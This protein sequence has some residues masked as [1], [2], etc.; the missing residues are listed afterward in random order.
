MGCNAFERL[1]SHNQLGFAAGI[2]FAYFNLKVFEA[3]SNFISFSPYVAI[4]PKIS[5]KTTLHLGGRYSVFSGDDDIED[6]EASST[7]KGT[8]FSV[9]FE[10]SLSRKTKFLTEGG[11]DF[12]FRGFRLGG[13]VL[14]GWEKFRVK[15]GV[16][17][18]DPENM[19]GFAFPVIGLW[20]RFNSL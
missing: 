12:T 2:D 1:P 9:G 17:Y 14:F 3:N 20:R 8:S 6:A 18:F 4:S 16:T 11:Y 19:S 10:Y 13:A 5:E 15:L 7:S